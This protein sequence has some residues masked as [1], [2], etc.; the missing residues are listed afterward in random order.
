LEKDS[1]FGVQARHLLEVFH[2]FKPRYLFPMRDDGRGLLRGKKGQAGKLRS[3]CP[4]EIQGVLL[5]R[6]EAF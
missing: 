5:K 6:N 2:G 3:R 4:V 1:L